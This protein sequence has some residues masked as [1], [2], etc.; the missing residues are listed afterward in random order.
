MTD[1]QLGSDL[2]I[3]IQVLP[4][5]LVKIAL[6]STNHGDQLEAALVVLLEL[7][8]ME[9]HAPDTLR[10]NCNLHLKASNVSTL[11][12]VLGPGLLRRLLCDVEHVL[13][14]GGKIEDLLPGPLT[15]QCL[16]TV[17]RCDSSS[18][19]EITGQIFLGELIKP[20]RVIFPGDLLLSLHAQFHHL[21]R[22][23]IL[24]LHRTQ[25]AH[26]APIL[27]LG[28][29]LYRC[30]LTA[31]VP[32]LDSCGHSTCHDNSPY[33]GKASVRSGR[34]QSRSS[35]SRQHCTLFER[36]LNAPTCRCL[37]NKAKRY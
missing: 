22:L 10:Q 27:T 6:T 31:E 13:L 33:R 28:E 20:V 16:F 25:R 3:R 14:G 36:Q 34:R 8:D 29:A 30:S 5:Q 12:P 9:N 21:C 37:G 17:L 15:S 11:W 24:S 19:F 7:A 4:S 23:V 35:A 32:A 26:D 2:Q 18:I 1:L